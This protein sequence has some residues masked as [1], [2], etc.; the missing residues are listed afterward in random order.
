MFTPDP[1]PNTLPSSALARV[2]PVRKYQADRLEYFP[3][4]GSIDH[5]LRT[6]RSSLVE[7]G[8]LLMVR[9][10]WHVNADLFDQAVL[11]IGRQE[12][13]RAIRKGATNL[14]ATS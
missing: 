8:A 1:T 12:A 5:F 10:V 9:G 11:D 4:K 14:L 13:A 3:S 6:H 2:S 7:C